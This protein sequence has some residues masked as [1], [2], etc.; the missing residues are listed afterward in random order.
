MRTPRPSVCCVQL[1]WVVQ[2]LQEVRRSSLSLK[3]ARQT[4]NGCRKLQLSRTWA[5]EYLRDVGTAGVPKFLFFTSLGFRGTP[6]AKSAPSPAGAVG[7]LE[8]EVDDSELLPF[9]ADGFAELLAPRKKVIRRQFK[10]CLP[11]PPNTGA[12][13]S[14][15]TVFFSRV[16]DWISDSSFDL[17]LVFGGS[18]ELVGGGGGGGGGAGGGGGILRYP[19]STKRGTC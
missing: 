6:F 3:E 8:A 5:F 2:V 10:P 17:S 7:P 19:N 14:L 9:D 12:D 4:A 1:E 18:D 13:L 11:P 16:P 15:V